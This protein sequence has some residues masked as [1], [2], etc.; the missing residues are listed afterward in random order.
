[1]FADAMREA[2]NQNKDLSRQVQELTTIRVQLQNE[3]D[4]FSTELSDTKDTLK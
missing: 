4:G 3:R 1:M 2:Q